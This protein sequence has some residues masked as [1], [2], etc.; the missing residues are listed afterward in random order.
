MRGVGLPRMPEIK[1]SQA[2]K[3]E[4]ERPQSATA[5]RFREMR[6]LHVTCDRFL[7]FTDETSHADLLATAR[8]FELLLLQTH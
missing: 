7:H 1:Q 3:A 2:A 5:E 8:I 6:P 4:R